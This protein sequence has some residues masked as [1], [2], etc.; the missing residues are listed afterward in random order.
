[1]MDLYDWRKTTLEI[2][3]VKKEL[4]TSITALNSQMCEN[5]KHICEENGLDVETVDGSTDLSTYLV[6]FKGN[7]SNSIQ[8]SRKFLVDIGMGFSVR[9]IIDREANT[10]LLLELYPFEEEESK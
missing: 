3:S 2:M 5:I 7:T 8:F 6:T 9:R 10:K 4:D 1:M